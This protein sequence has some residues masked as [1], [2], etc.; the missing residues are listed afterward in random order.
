MHKVVG[1]SVIATS[2]GWLL[3][4]TVLIGPW[5]SHLGTFTDAQSSS[6]GAV[7]VGASA[8]VAAGVAWV[9]RPLVTAVL[10]ADVSPF[11][12]RSSPWFTV[13]ATTAAVINT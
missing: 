4:T 10:A 3:S 5:S 13:I 7:V 6:G 12:E 2:M 9:D 8:E 1:L 11:V